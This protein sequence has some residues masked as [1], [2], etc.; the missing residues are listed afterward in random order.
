MCAQRGANL[1]VLQE[2]HCG[3]YFCQAEDTSMFDWAN[4][5]PGPDT[6]VFSDAA[7]KYGVVL[8]FFTL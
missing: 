5:I 1:V 7:R 8:V 3:P 4:P 6:D 2:L